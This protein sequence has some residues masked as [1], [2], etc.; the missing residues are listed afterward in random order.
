MKLKKQE[1]EALLRN[2]IRKRSSITEESANPFY[3]S[4]LLDPEQVTKELATP[5]GAQKVLDI[6]SDMRSKGLLSTITSLSKK[7][8]VPREILLGIVIDEQLRGFGKST[9]QGSD[10]GDDILSFFRPA[11]TS[12]GA[13]QVKP[14]LVFDLVRQGWKPEHLSSVVYFDI[15]NHKGKITRDIGK[16]ISRELKVNPRLGIE[17][18]AKN[19][20]KEKAM[21]SKVKGLEDWSKTSKSWETV[22]YTSMGAPTLKKGMVSPEERQKMGLPPTPDPSARGRGIGQIA[23][24]AKKKGELGRKRRPLATASAGAPT[25]K[26]L[27]RAVG[28]GKFPKLAMKESEG[29]DDLLRQLIREEIEVLSEKKYSSTQ[30]AQLGLKAGESVLGRQLDFT[31]DNVPHTITFNRDHIV[32]DG[33]KMEL[34]TGRF[35]STPVKIKKMIVGKPGEPKN[36]N[37]FIVAPSIAGQKHLDSNAVRNI[38]KHALL[39][40]KKLGMG[41]TYSNRVYGFQVKMV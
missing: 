40:A 30:I 14:T 23:S 26:A 17:A 7:Y 4:V 11:R 2:A 21:W 16:K 35:S 33:V 1:L 34:S 37:N 10:I 24:L 13:A 25:G 41:K 32:L 22:A 3:G 29:S 20:A 39:P 31:V 8:G 6:I 38:V 36:T 5:E 9:L 18:V 27:A 12:V 28:T 19:L 15:R